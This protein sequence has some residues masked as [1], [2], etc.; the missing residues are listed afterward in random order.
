MPR[1][2]YHRRIDSIRGLEMDHHEG[3]RTRRRW[4]RRLG[5]ALIALG[6][7][8]TSTACGSAFS[9]GPDAPGST[10]ALPATATASEVFAGGQFVDPR[11]EA[12]RSEAELRAAGD[13]DDADAVAQ[14]SGE[15]TAIWLGDW[16]PADDLPRVLG[17]YREEAAA[18]GSTLVFVLSGM[19]G[20]DCTRSVAGGG[21]SERDYLDWVRVV[22]EEL[23][24]SRA[25]I[26]LEPDSVATLDGESC[27]DERERR[28]PLLR[29][30]VD[31]LTAAGLTVYLDGGHNGLILEDRMAQLLLDAGIDQARGFFSNVSNFYRVDEVRPYAERV[32]ALLDRKSFVIDVSRSGVGGQPDWCNP[33]EAALGQPPEVSTDAS[34]LDALLW[35]KRPGESDGPCDGAPRAGDWYLD[36]AVTLVDN[37]AEGAAR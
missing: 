34:S 26:M 3:R 11:S 17:A 33:P 1:A 21:F 22:A 18:D 5:A 10:G 27:T 37:R 32:S 4:S 9:A 36:Y 12:V 28:I 31:T 20:R 24:G 19:A 6:M 23:S 8:T 7:A 30:A 2:G 25:V 16:Y 13:D 14:I 29:G 15:P 35:I